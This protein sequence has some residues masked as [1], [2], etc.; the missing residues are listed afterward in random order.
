MCIYQ[1]IFIDSNI[2]Q[3]NKDI[4]NHSFMLELILNFAN[5]I[6]L[7]YLIGFNIIVVLQI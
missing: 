3:R 4:L 1:S 5:I 6:D 7:G 2:L